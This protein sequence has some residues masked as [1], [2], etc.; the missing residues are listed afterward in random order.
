MKNYFES[1]DKAEYYIAYVMLDNELREL[2]K[3]LQNKEGYL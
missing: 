3:L 1:K 2:N